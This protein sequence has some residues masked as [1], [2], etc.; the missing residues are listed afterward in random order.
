MKAQVIWSQAVILIRCDSWIVGGDTREREIWRLVERAMR[1]DESR[2]E[3]KE[4]DT[5]SKR[6]PR[7]KGPAGAATPIECDMSRPLASIYFTA[8]KST[9]W[10][11]GGFGQ[12]RHVGKGRWQFYQVAERKIY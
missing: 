2:E 7:S 3:E 11:C 1:E 8:S 9:G 12:L 6:K 4:A 10:S 5:K